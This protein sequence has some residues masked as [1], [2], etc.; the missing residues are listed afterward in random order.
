MFS[1]YIVLFVSLEVIQPKILSK[2]TKEEKYKK[3]QKHRRIGSLI[4]ECRINTC[5]GALRSQKIANIS[6]N[7]KMSVYSSS[8][9]AFLQIT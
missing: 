2:I 4:Q 3:S 7:C 1:N 9:L 6:E 8:V 5:T